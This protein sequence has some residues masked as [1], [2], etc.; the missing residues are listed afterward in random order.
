MPIFKE[1]RDYKNSASRLQ[2]EAIPSTRTKKL[3]NRYGKLWHY[4][5]D[6]LCSLNEIRAKVTANTANFIPPSRLLDPDL[7]GVIP[8]SSRHAKTAKNTANKYKQ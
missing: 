1:H 6:F 5:R 8:S 4:F 7:A 3:V 2:G